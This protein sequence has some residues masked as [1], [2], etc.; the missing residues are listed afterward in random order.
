MNFIDLPTPYT[1][2][3]RFPLSIR[4]Y[5]SQNSSDYVKEKRPASHDSGQ[6]LHLFTKSQNKMAEKSM[7]TPLSA[8]NL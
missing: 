6:K 5:A 4:V 8:N 7:K 3:L 1:K 2:T